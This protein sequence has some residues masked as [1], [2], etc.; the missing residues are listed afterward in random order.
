MG[1]DKK[2]DA[3]LSIK[4]QGG[5]VAEC[6]SDS[7]FLSWESESAPVTEDGSVSYQVYFKLSREE[8][9][10][11]EDAEGES[12]T[13]TDLDPV[14]EYDIFV[15][16]FNSDDEVVCR[17]PTDDN[18]MTVETTIA[19]DEEAPIVKSDE[20]VVKDISGDSFTIQWEE[21]TDNR[22]EK[23]QI[24]Y[25]VALK[26]QGSGKGTWKTESAQERGSHTFTGLKPATSYRYRVEA[27]DEA[28]NSL[29][30]KEGAVETEDTVAP[31]VSSAKLTATPT[32]TSVKL[33]WELATDN[34]TAP[35]DIRYRVYRTEGDEWMAPKEVTGVGE[36]TFNGLTPATF[37]RFR[38]QA[39]DEAGS[40]FEYQYI[41]VMTKD[42]VA[43][44]VNDPQLKVSS[45]GPLNVTV[46]WTPATDNKTAQRSIR[47]RIY[48]SVNG[49]WEK[50]KEVI[51][52][53]SCAFSDLKQ[54]TRYVFH[55]EAL[56]ESNNVLKYNDL[57]YETQDIERPSPSNSALTL[58]TTGPTI[59]VRWTPATDNVT[60]QNKIVY[61]VYRAE[62][63]SA[64]QS[65]VKLTG[66]DNHTFSGL[67]SATQYTVRVEAVD[68]AGNVYQYAD[69]SIKT[70]DFE[71]PKVTN[72]TLTLTTV[73]DRVTIQWTPATDDVTASG[74][75][76][77]KISRT[78]GGVWQSPVKQTGG[79]SYQFTGLKPA[80]QYSFRVVA[81]D[82]AGNITQYN[83]GTIKTSDYEAPVA[84][85]R[86]L[87][88]TTSRD[89]ITVSWKPATDNVTSS[90]NIIYK[91][92]RT[93]GDVWQSPVKQRG[94]SYYTFN[95]L[96]SATRYS[97]RVE[98]VDEA[99]NT[100]SYS[101]NAIMTKDFER[102]KVTN[103]TLTLSATRYDVTVKWTP[104]TDLV[105]SSGNIL[106]KIYRTEG[107]AWQT[108]KQLRGGSSCQF[109][110]LKPATRYSFRV[111][112]IDEAGNTYQYS[113][114]STYTLEGTA[115]TVGSR[116]LTR[117][118]L[119][120]KGFTIRWQ[121]A[122]DNSTSSSRIRYK[123]LLKEYDNPNDP[124]RTVKDAYGIS[125]HVFTGLKSNVKY[126]YYVMA[127]DEAGNSLQYPN[128]GKCDLVTTP[129]LINSFTLYIEQ[130]ASV[131]SGTNS[132]AL[133]VVYN[134]FQ[135]DA[136]RN[137]TGQAAVN[138]WDYKW[139]NKKGT[140]KVFTLPANWYFENNRV[141]V[142]VKTRV[143]AVSN[144]KTNSEGDV[145]ISGG[146]LTLKLSGHYLKNSVKF[147]Q[148]K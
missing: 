48:R 81:E 16:G 121:A 125:S 70:N 60:A 25:E 54:A 59:T 111:E 110:G 21:A 127:Y 120:F 67:K 3:R 116:V 145:D 42:T 143:T 28:G 9:W 85:S 65:P 131:L 91:I 99:G 8:L 144:W 40:C 89:T 123:V 45:T 88:L 104:A 124:W 56:D 24:R 7:I 10:S 57:E 47:Y 134:S 33:E 100:Y 34:V 147:T 32:G 61:R 71:R 103:S 82:E 22:T 128:D 5:L 26:Q 75:I 141:H 97:I 105:T 64:L 135:L 132:V 83:D 79:S 129:P 12:Y 148:V 39:V 76:L 96:K 78:E 66:A 68:E 112:A 11:V 122:N 84:S 126:G 98:A 13:L 23:D 140:S 107:G 77:Y 93:E 92:Y 58:T 2:N 15:Q 27:V 36:Y 6:S 86:V 41:D 52:V 63:G 117:S 142:V 43:P 72:T 102:P 115:P 137:R 53:D 139:S 44:K 50:P 136:N 18:Y 130:T 30:Y 94:G 114:N 109:T 51:G 38:V 74:R 14:S 62:T 35:S 55:V 37:Y 1:K 87:T 138:S 29:E 118:D 20:V 133:E 90:G 113:D 106:Y 73:R 49:T 108:P 46:H 69:K 19:P 146:S 119:N 17:F 4:K 31:E 101:D 95:C 80:T